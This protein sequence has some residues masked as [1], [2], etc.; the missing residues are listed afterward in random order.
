MLPLRVK[1]NEEAKRLFKPSEWK[2]AAKA[3]GIAAGRR[4]IAEDLPRRFTSFAVELGYSTKRKLSPKQAREVAI[5]AAIATMRL[6]G[7]YK[8]IVTEAC[9][10]WGGWDPTAPGGAPQNVWKRWASEALKSGKIK[11]SLNGEWKSAR[12]KMR[13]EVKQASRL[14]ERVRNFAID[15]YLDGDGSEKLPLVMTGDLRSS[16]E[17]T[18]RP[19]VTSAKES[20]VIAVKFARPHPLN[21]MGNR[22]LKATTQDEADRV[23]ETFANVMQAFVNG[24]RVIKRGKNKGQRRAT[25]QQKKGQA[26]A[27]LLA[28]TASRRAAR[29]KARQSRAHKNRNANTHKP[30]G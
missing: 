1:L 2:R 17:R 27:I 6:D 4:F 23:G 16:A 29:S 26:M 25:K 22:V 9:A 19:A 13:A 18:A 10:P 28:E 20:T 21:A 30:R 11:P 7:N 14:V 12:Q 24:S 5:R 8:R 15:N 3:A